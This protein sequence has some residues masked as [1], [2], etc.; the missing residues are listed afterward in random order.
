LQLELRPC[1]VY[2]ALCVLYCLFAGG[3]LE[4][5]VLLEALIDRRWNDGL[6]VRKVSIHYDLSGVDTLLWV[7]N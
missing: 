2:E 1:L 4:E 6:H 7:E 3:L 5:V